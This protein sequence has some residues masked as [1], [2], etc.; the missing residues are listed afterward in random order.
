M[1]KNRTAAEWVY[2][3]RVERDITG[4]VV[5]HLIQDSTTVELH[6]GDEF[7]TVHLTV[8]PYEPAST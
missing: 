8:D 1:A 6:E 5:L 2:L 3:A 4:G 7:L